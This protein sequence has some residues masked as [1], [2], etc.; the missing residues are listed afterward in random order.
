MILDGRQKKLVP[1]ARMAAGAK[2]H[3]L[4]TELPKSRD[5]GYQ[6]SFPGDTTL[7]AALRD[8]ADKRT[9]VRL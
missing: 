4:T 3:W 2:I 1:T 8:I 7:L 6:W 9:R 5:R